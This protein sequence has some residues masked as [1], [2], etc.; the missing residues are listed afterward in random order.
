MSNDTTSN[1]NQESPTKLMELKQSTN[2]D[3]TPG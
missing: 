2:P 3:D 1:N